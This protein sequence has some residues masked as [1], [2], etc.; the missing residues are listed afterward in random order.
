MTKQ[1]KQLNLVESLNVNELTELTE[2]TEL[3]VTHLRHA[4]SLDDDELQDSLTPPSYTDLVDPNK[5]LDQTISNGS[6]CRI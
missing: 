1:I 3:S 5:Q 4:L 6:R 2:L